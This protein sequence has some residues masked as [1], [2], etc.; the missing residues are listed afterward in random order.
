MANNN[1][2][3]SIINGPL[4]ESV[5]DFFPST[6]RS[7]E[8]VWQHSQI[9]SPGFPITYCVCVRRVR[10]R[11]HSY[12]HYTPTHTHTQS[13]D[14]GVHGRVVFP[15]YYYFYCY[16]YDLLCEVIILSLGRVLFYIVCSCK[17]YVSDSAQQ[18][19]STGQH[20]YSNECSNRLHA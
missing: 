11:G 20:L 14:I 10:S 3:G 8:Y 9:T 4:A 17:M 15:F 13:A 1:F 5:N 18:N 2:K 16:Y 6:W 19:S 7:S 12:T